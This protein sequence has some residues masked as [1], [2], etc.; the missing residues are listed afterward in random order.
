MRLELVRLHRELKTTMIYV[1]HDQLE[2][3][4]MA[5]RIVV[6]N[7]GRVEQWGSPLELYQNPATLFVAGFIGAPRMNLLDA[8][9]K[10]TSNQLLCLVLSNGACVTVP[11]P[12]EELKPGEAIKLGVRPEHVAIESEGE[13]QGEIDALEHL[14]P[15]AYLHAGLPDGSRL[16]VQAD[17][18]TALRVGD[19]VAFR[20]RAQA[21]H[22]FD[23]TGRAL[24]RP[25]ARVL[26]H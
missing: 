24:T 17:G 15:R 5:D 18:D 19:R 12:V 7:G 22:L 9:V 6:L 25:G 8:V 13:L 21:T 1:T 10:D 3:M 14:G 23:R 16:V 11:A 2:A 4:T 26:A 20:I